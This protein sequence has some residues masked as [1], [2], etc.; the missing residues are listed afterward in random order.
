MKILVTGSSGHLGEAL[1]RT[2][3]GHDVVALDVIEGPLTTHVGSIV[4]RDLVAACMKDVEVVLHTATLH[5]PH[6]ATHSR[7]NFV[8]TM[9]DNQSDRTNMQSTWF[10]KRFLTTCFS[11]IRFVL[12][13]E[14]ASKR[15]TWVCY[16]AEIRSFSPQ[17]LFRIRLVFI[18]LQAFFSHASFGRQ[19]REGKK[20]QSHQ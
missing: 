6:V 11:S 14:M 2:L 19:I 9:P 7:Q 8:D 18:S 13:L 3:T 10:R 5:K 1:V 20:P 12:I 4:D 17:A 15:S 16:W